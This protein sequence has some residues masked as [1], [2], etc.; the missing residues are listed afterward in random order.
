MLFPDYHFCSNDWAGHENVS[1]NLSYAPP[2]TKGKKRN[3]EQQRI[4]IASSTVAQ[5]S[6]NETAANHS[7]RIHQSSKYVLTPP[8]QSP[9]L[10][11]CWDL[12]EVD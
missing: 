2:V 6:S 1:P 11:G 7:S 4:Q 3:K 9:V 10:L 5:I 12:S 8:E